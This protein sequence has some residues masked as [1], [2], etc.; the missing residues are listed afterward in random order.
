MQNG[1]AARPLAGG[2]VFDRGGRQSQFEP[3]RTNGPEM[4]WAISA[5]V[6]KGNW[7]GVEDKQRK[8]LGPRRA[9]GPKRG[10]GKWVE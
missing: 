6:P 7:T 3:K 5:D 9:F 2:G 4:S 1:A 10:M 8:G